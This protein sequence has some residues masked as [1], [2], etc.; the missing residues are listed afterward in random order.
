MVTFAN[1]TLLATGSFSSII[2]WDL[3]SFENL[4]TIKIRKFADFLAAFDDKL[5]N[6]AN[7]R[8]EIEI[9]NPFTGEL[10]KVLYLNVTHRFTGVDGLAF[11]KKDHIVVAHSNALFIWNIDTGKQLQRII[12]HKGQITRL[13]V[14]AD[15]SI[16]ST[17]ADSTIKIWKSNNSNQIAEGKLL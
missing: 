7:Y 5:V 1:G 14:L 10:V 6:A 15:G 16:I 17:S 9:W 13:A 4:R 3:A 12:A 8:P 2:I 11:L